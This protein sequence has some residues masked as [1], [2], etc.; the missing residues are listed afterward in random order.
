[1]CASCAGMTTRSAWWSSVT[2][3]RAG[4]PPGVRNL[5]DERATRP[6]LAPHGPGH[7]GGSWSEDHGRHPWRPL[8]EVQPLRDGR[9]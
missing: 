9:P 7:A 8:G 2:A 5:R 6:T 3:P 4:S 1:M